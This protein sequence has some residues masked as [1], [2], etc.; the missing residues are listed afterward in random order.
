MWN[1]LT[2]QEWNRRAL[3]LLGA[4]LV[5]RL[6]F[7]AIFPV[8]PAGDEAYYWDWGRQLDFGYYSKPPFIAW[9]Y[10]FV[11]WIGGGSLYAIR[12]SA[13][14]L[15]TTAAFLL[16]RLT[17][18]LFDVR[19]GW[20]AL[21]LGL[22]APANSVL[23]FFLTIDA[24]LTVCWTVALWMTWRYVSENGGVGTLVTLFLALSI[25]HLSKQMMMIFPLI[26]IAFLLTEKR[27]RPFLKRPG[28]LL[29]L[30]GSYLALIPPLVW[31]AQHDWITLQHT[32][33]HFGTSPVVENIFLERAEEFFTFLATQM[34]VLAPLTAIILFTVSLTQL[35]LFR[36]ASRPVRF[37]LLFGAV[38]L[39]A[40]LLLALRQ[41]LQPNW[42]AVFYVSCIALTAAWFSLRVRR[43]GWKLTRSE[44]ARRITCYLALLGGVLL[45]LYFYFASPILAM[46]DVPGHRADPNRRMMGHDVMA[47]EYQK[48]REAQP[49]GGELFV[50]A[51]G[52]RDTASH[53]AF[54][55]PDQPRVYRWE[56]SGMVVSQYEVW[57]TPIEDGLA[58]RDAL[59]LMSFNPNLPEDL[60]KRFTS[61]EKVGEFNAVYG[62][63]RTFYF[64]VHRGIGLKEWPR[65]LVPGKKDEEPE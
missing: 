27:T 15:G 16:F 24:P 7:A 49:D 5:F 55:L 11:D 53:L 44:N 36:S 51:M 4:V 1:G 50:V 54:S 8:N 18:S 58:G 64:S 22:A 62:Y 65:P 60:A 63:D 47:A 13:A 46:F 45:S 9:L 32:K 37:L 30:F 10:S 23:S 17:S 2:D 29:A 6:V 26:V 56:P 40:M 35:A 52:H 20:I 21:L 42:P 48:I 34:G 38:P 12:A 19:T 3:L 31:N 28:L 14:I 57:N 61:T 59:I 33:H 41:K 43:P 25:G 39:A